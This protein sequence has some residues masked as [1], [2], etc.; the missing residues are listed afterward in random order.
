ML[1]TS[2]DMPGV[3]SPRERALQFFE[4]TRREICIPNLRSR[5]TSR[6]EIDIRKAIEPLTCRRVSL[7]DQSG[8]KEDIADYVE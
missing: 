7:H 1:S 3:Q 6:P 5:V 4:G 2:P 8:L